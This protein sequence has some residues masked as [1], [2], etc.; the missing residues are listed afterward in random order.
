MVKAKHWIMYVPFKTVVDFILTKRTRHVC[1]WL[2]NNKPFVNKQILKCS[3]NLCPALKIS[4]L[5]CMLLNIFQLNCRLK[6]KNWSKQFMHACI[7]LF[8][9]FRGIHLNKSIETFVLMSVECQK[10]LCKTY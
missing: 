3:Q 9:S 7:G 10:W 5:P 4:M 6:L 8:V 2:C 1:H